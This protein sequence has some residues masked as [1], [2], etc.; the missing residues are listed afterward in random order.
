MAVSE[1]VAFT[2]TRGDAKERSRLLWSPPDSLSAE[3]SVFVDRPLINTIQ[4]D[5]SGF[6]VACWSFSTCLWDRD[7]ETTMQR[8]RTVSVMSCGVWV[9]SVSSH[10]GPP[11]GYWHCLCS[12]TRRQLE[13][14]NGGQREAVLLWWRTCPLCGHLRLW[15]MLP[16]KVAFAEP[17]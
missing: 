12:P 4:D 2:P 9:R 1:L 14:Q 5:R 7:K 13:M 15:Q 11:L 3:Q 10:S 8:N 16:S 17:P 6:T